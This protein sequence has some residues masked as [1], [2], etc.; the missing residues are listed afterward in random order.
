MFLSTDWVMDCSMSAASCKNG[1]DRRVSILDMTID[2][3][4]LILVRSLASALCMCMT[5]RAHQYCVAVTLVLPSG[6]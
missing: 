6:V 4:Q 2:L 1:D 3:T 5:D